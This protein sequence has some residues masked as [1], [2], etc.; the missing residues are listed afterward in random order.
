MSL[1]PS[2]VDITPTGVPVGPVVAA[3]AAV[4]EEGVAPVVS[5][6]GYT[7]N[8][9]DDDDEVDRNGTCNGGVAPEEE[10]MESA[11]TA[12]EPAGPAPLPR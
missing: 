9:H 1:T 8:E 3:G 7:E 6:T 12:E 2:P 10:D 4:E 11:G 5:E